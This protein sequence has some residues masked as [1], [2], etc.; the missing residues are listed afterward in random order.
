MYPH[1]DA[2]RTAYCRRQ[3]VA[4]ATAA[5]ATGV[6]AIRQAYLELE[7]GWLC[8]EPKVEASPGAPADRTHD[9]EPAPKRARASNAQS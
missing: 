4:C 6:A 7:Q 3:A 5:V 1:Q 9:R 2:E 8:L